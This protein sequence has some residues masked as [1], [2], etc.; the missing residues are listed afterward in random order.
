MGGAVGHGER[1]G[2]AEV[3]GFRD[4]H[5]VRRWRHDL[6]GIAA[7]RQRGH[8]PVAG[9]QLAGVFAEFLYHAG[10]FEAW[11]ERE[12]R[13]ELVPTRDHQVVSEV[14]PRGPYREPHLPGC[15]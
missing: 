15:G 14:D 10:D 5:D 8:H 1:C 13:L 11:A 9:L 2:G 7:M 4:R 12:R 6:L 3:H